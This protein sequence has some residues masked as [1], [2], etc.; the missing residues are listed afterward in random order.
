MND[1][2]LDRILRR[3]AVAEV[4]DDAG[5]TAR[6]MG[7]LPA[8]ASRARNGFDPMLVLG[9]AAL[10]SVLA[11]A[12]TPTEA[13]AMQGAIDLF[14]HHALTPAAYTC[15][16]LSAVLVVSAVLFAKES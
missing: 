10:G 16:G 3:D 8:R 13:N 9:S 1:D 12:F 15:I 11:V 2:K 6:V 7:S 4:L 14:L 5:F